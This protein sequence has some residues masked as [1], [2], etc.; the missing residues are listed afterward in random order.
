MTKKSENNRKNN[1]SGA[2]IAKDNGE[3]PGA[4]SAQY[5]QYLLARVAGDVASGIAGA[6]SESVMT[7]EAIATVAVDVAE[8]ILKKV[9]L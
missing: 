8:E 4:K 7:A 5:R 3:D 2:K 6:P 9:G 1:V